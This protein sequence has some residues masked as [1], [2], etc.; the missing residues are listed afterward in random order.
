MEALRTPLALQN[1]AQQQVVNLDE[2]TAQAF[3]KNE[4]MVRAALAFLA[5]RAPGSEAATLTTNEQGQR[6]IAAGVLDARL[7]TFIPIAKLMFKETPSEVEISKATQESYAVFSDAQRLT[8]PYPDHQVMTRAQLL[9]P[10]EYYTG[11]AQVD[12]ELRPKIVALEE[13][14]F[15]ARTGKKP[16][17]AVDTKQDDYVQTIN[18]AVDYTLQQL[19]VQSAHEV[20]GTQPSRTPSTP[21]P[22]GAEVSEQLR[23][24]LEHPGFRA[25]PAA[26]QQMILAE[27]QA[28]AQRIGRPPGELAAL[29]HA[30]SDFRPEVVNPTS[31][32]TGLGQLVGSTARRYGV[33][34]AKNIH[35]NI[36]GSAEEWA[37]AMRAADNDPIRAYRDYYHSNPTSAEL[38]RFR[39]ALHKYGVLTT[40]T[41]QRSGLQGRTLP[42]VLATAP[43][44]IARGLSNVYRTLSE[45][46]TPAPP[47]TP[48]AFVP[49]LAGAGLSDAD[50]YLA[51]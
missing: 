15:Q 26:T 16:A 42:P 22:P 34:D 9:K 1:E 30:E 45:G 46:G 50:R 20:L 25:L 27:T 24:V 31:G 44:K 43:H 51:R 35:Q 5:S 47:V 40:A 48:S 18:K 13:A 19:R 11:Q 6:L 14:R 28:Q 21:I 37:R 17:R 10:A 23:P 3:G 8:I 33:T 36:Q 4:P 12:Q 2:F 29:F 49:G 41:E 39:Q 7:K 32:A 38:E